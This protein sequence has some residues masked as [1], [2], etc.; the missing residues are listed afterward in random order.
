MNASA[1]NRVLIVDDHFDTLQ[2]IVRLLQRNGYAV[3]PATTYRE[4]TEVAMREGCKLLVSDITLPDGS[5]LDLMR[6]LAPDGVLGIA[7]SGH[8]SPDDAHAAH[9]AGFKAYL[10]K[11]IRFADLMESLNRLTSDEQPS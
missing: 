5:G 10:V 9:V 3:C 11:P 8:A 6:Q 1:I 7:I 4:A 2:S